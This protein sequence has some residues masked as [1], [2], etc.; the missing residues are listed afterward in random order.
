MKRSIFDE[1][2]SKALTQWRKNAKKK[3]DGKLGGLPTEKLG[4][5]P[6]ETVDLETDEPSE[7]GPY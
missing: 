2:T 6:N 7:H 4:Q 3:N 1:Q 5:L